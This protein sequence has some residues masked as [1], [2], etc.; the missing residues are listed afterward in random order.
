MIFQDQDQDDIHVVE[1]FRLFYDG[2]VCVPSLKICLKIK[3]RFGPSS[4]NLKHFPSVGMAEG[5]KVHPIL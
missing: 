5:L 3:L 1:P 4:S 2:G